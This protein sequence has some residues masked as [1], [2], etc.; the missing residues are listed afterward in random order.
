MIGMSDYQFMGFLAGCNQY[1]VQKDEDDFPTVALDNEKTF[2]IYSQLHSLI[3]DTTSAR[4]WV[5][6]SD[7]SVQIPFE[8]NQALFW[9]S[10]GLSEAVG[11]R[12]M[13]TDFGI[14]PFPK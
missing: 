7:K 14:I 13:E 10:G 8:S 12:S 3:Y 9:I 1:V 2:D 5:Y 6:G 11:L 4:V